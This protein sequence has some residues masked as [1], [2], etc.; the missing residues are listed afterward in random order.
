MGHRIP[1]NYLLS[2][3]GYQAQGFPELLDEGDKIL[4]EN[5]ILHYGSADEAMPYNFGPKDAVG[6]PQRIAKLTLETAHR[7]RIKKDRALDIGCSV[8]G[9]TFELARGFESVLG[10]D[11]S[12]TFIDA[13]QILCRE[14][15]LA[16]SRPDEGENM[17]QAEVSLPESLDCRRVNFRRADACALPPELL[18]FDV[19][20][21][22][23]IICR[24]ASPRA[25]L[26]RLC[27]ARGLVR[28]G[29]LLVLATPFTWDERFTPRDAWLGGHDGEDSFTVLQAQLNQDFESLETRDL[30]FLI[31]EHARKFQYV[32]TLVSLW[33]RRG[34]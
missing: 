28:S 24:L 5:P 18:G 21:A 9:S 12:A 10:I 27:G 25:F 22:A 7:L 23:N 14:G 16:Y 11:L 1:L 30:P 15:R 8:G 33:K 3:L 26:G 13:A 20:L 6:F 17:R 31:R 19:V 29:G 4:A 2:L 32:V 34:G